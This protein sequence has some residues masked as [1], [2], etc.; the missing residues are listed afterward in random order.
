MNSLFSHSHIDKSAMFLTGIDRFNLMN[1][2]N[3][4]LSLDGSNKK[5]SLKRSLQHVL[6]LAP[7][8]A[9]K[10]T[11]YIIPNLLRLK[12]SS[13]IVL[14]PSQEIFNLCGK[15]LSKKF[16]VKVLNVTN[17]SISERWNPLEK[18]IKSPEDI[19]K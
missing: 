7:S 15:K 14:D 18:G 3:T 8:G 11:S 5:I 19:K 17:L 13:S 10:T 6:V 12:H 2:F 1:R 4:G 9:G 16:D